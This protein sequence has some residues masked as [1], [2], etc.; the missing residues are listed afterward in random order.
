MTTPVG[1]AFI[2]A[3]AVSQWHAAAVAACPQ[4]QLCGVYDADTARAQAAATSYGCRHYATLDALLSDTSVQAVVVLSPLEYHAKHALQSL[5]ASKHVMIEKPVATQLADV[6]AIEQQAQASQRICMPAHNYIYA[7]QLRSAKRLIDEG[8][9]GQIVSAWIVYSM[10]HP[11]HIAAK[12]PGVLRQ[13]MTHH[14][15]SLLYLLGKPKR[16][17][18]LASESRTGADKLDREDQV[19]LIAEMPN[20]ALVNLFA[21]FAADDQTSDPWTV[22]YKILGTNGGSVYSWRDSVRLDS[23]AGLAWRY[24]NYEESFAH[25]INYFVQHCI[26]GGQQPLSTI[27]DAAIAQQLVEAAELSIETGKVVGV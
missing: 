13:I 3:G 6:V 10:Y 27:R 22:L 19:T 7:P 14:F 21:S 24:P 2:G 23:G 15:Y 11:P 8:A 1:I 9:F 26:L 17:A 5:Q 12:Y 16:I 18:A 20:G 25:E 4:A